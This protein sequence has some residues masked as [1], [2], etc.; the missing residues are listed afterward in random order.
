MTSAKVKAIYSLEGDLDRYSPV[1]P[2]H[3]S[4][5]VRVIV[6]PRESDGEE[7]FDMTVCTPNFLA[8]VCEKRGFV[9]GRHY[10]F[11][12]TYRAPLKK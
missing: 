5:Q 8:S 7:S 3:F 12:N 9:V 4:V 2:D 11:V 1:E 10:L 6:G